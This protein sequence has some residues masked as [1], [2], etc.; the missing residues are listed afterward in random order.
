VTSLGI[1]NDSGALFSNRSHDFAMVLLAA[2]SRGGTAAQ[3]RL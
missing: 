1:V 3:T 2:R